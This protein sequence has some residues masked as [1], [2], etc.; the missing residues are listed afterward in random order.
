MHAIQ[1]K[2]T[3]A[4]AADI[5]SFSTERPGEFQYPM[6]ATPFLRLETIEGMHSVRSFV[7]SVRAQNGAVVHRAPL[8]EPGHERRAFI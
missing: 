2:Q 4:S 8:W 5:L 3:C 6:I 1:S 7:S